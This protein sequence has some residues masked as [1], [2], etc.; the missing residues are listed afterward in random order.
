MELTSSAF[1]NNQTIPVKYTCDGQ[2]INPPL[3]IIRISEGA[4]SLVL[5]VDDPDAPAGDWVHWLVWNIAPETSAIAEDSVPEG[6]VQGT[7]DFGKAGWGGPCPPSGSHR[8]QFKIYALDC[9]LGLASE[10]K[11]VDL[12]KVIA[13]RIL[14]QA[15]LIGKYQRRQ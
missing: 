7:T 4:K 6:A 5:V 13:G 3:T 12:E 9:R 8:Y 11:K 2:D 15:I 1:E 14:A 10:A